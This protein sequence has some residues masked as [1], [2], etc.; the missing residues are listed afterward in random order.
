MGWWMACSIQF[1]CHLEDWDMVSAF[2][3]V[4]KHIILTVFNQT[5][6]TS[7]HCS[8]SGIGEYG[9][10]FTTFGVQTEMK[11]VN[12]NPGRPA[13][14]IKNLVTSGNQLNPPACLPQPTFLEPPISTL[15]PPPSQ[16]SSQPSHRAPSQPNPPPSTPQTRQNPPSTTKKRLSQCREISPLPKEGE[17]STTE[18]SRPTGPRTENLT[19]LSNGP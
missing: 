1:R 13:K 5:I 4:C 6:P 17:L 15:Q 12:F 10:C 7:I 9:S 2:Y 16:C 18:R 8:C 3:R 19:I 14:T 11:L